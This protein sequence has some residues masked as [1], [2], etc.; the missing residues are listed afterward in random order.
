MSAGRHRPILVTGSLRSGTSWAGNML[1][2]SGEAGYIHE[3]FN[4][5]RL[6]GWAGGLFPHWF[7]YVCDE[8]E[9]AYAATIERIL[10]HRYP[11]FGQLREVTSRRRA[12]RFEEVPLVLDTITIDADRGLA[13]CVWRGT[14][15]LDH[16]ALEPEGLAKLFV[17]DEPNAE[18]SS[19][20]ACHARMQAKVEAD[21]AAGEELD[22]EDPPDVPETMQTM[23]GGLSP[24][25]TAIGLAYGRD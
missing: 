12:G 18:R 24:E 17:M 13:L 1:C 16:D 21:A 25:L 11:F 5:S 23:A 6:P 15:E 19:L 7:Q 3:P 4:V 10:H 2:R 8:N 20:E 14:V 22:A 9:S